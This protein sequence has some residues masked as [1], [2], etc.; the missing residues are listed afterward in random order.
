MASQTHGHFDI[1]RG[2][3]PFFHILTASEE[4]WNNEEETDLIILKEWSHGTKNVDFVLFARKP[5]SIAS[6]DGKPRLIRGLS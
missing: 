1:K 6:N 3:A 5:P 4:V 2:A